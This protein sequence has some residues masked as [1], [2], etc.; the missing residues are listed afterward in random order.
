MHPNEAL[1]AN[2]AFYLAFAARDLDHMDAL[3]SRNTPVICLHPG[4]PALTS[5]EDILSSWARIFGN[6]Q[7]EAVEIYGATAFEVGSTVLVVC[8]EMLGGN[9]M[10][11]SNLFIEE[12][13]AVV[14][15]HHQ[16][17]PCSQPPPLPTRSL[18]A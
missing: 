3:W 8:Y 16:A 7:Q 13:G 2:D 12:D 4:W 9:V 1:F 6:P 11:A 5:R 18:D 15:A 17:G 10:V 14:L